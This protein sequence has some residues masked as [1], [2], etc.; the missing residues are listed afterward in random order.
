[1]DTDRTRG[2]TRSV[3]RTVAVGFGAVYTLV[4]LAGFLVSDTFVGRTDDLLL[5]FM[6]NNLHNIA[7]LLI[8]VA[9]LAASRT[10]AAARSA[11]LAIG[12]AYLGLAV[13]GPFL[14][15]TNANILALN[16]PDHVLHLLSGALLTA[17]AVL[18]DK[19]TT[20]RSRV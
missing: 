11:N 18:A 14:T 8:G 10:H 5:G 20:A 12:V 7:H 4:G 19:S 13:V 1:M 16:N 9:L 15:G 6:V 2:A 17:V 3:N